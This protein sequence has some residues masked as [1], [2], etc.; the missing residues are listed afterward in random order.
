MSARSSMLAALTCLALAAACSAPA[1]DAPSDGDAVPEDSSDELKKTAND[2][3]AAQEKLVLQLID[4][5]CGDSWCEGDHDYFF[6]KMRCSFSAKT[7]TITM[8]II[9]PAYDGAAERDFWRSCKMK[10][11][12]AFTSMVD[13]APNGYQSLNDS[14]YD[15][16]NGCIDKLE[17]TIPAR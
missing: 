14:F 6:A 1:S 11:V 17:A 2:L 10:D 13:T 9:D 4:D 3:T 16:V 7:C 15:K 8:K 5:I 12:D